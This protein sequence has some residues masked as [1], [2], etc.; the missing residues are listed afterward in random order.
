MLNR[1]AAIAAARKVIEAAPMIE[2]GGVNEPVIDMAKL[3]DEVLTAANPDAL[4][5]P[6]YDSYL[7]RDARYR[8]EQDTE[9][10]R[11]ALL[12]ILAHPRVVSYSVTRDGNPL[13]G[14]FVAPDAAWL[15]HLAGLSAAVAA[16]ELGEGKPL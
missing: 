11:G 12:S 3:V 15:T 1:A 16:R 7:A 13:V 2:V 6:P 8:L 5:I 9:D 4:V 10:G 14:G